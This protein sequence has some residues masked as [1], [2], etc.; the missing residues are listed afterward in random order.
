MQ[1]LNDNK[2]LTILI[3]AL[4]FYSA[5]AGLMETIQRS[6]ALGISSEPLRKENGIQ[7]FKTKLPKNGVVAYVTDNHY[8]LKSLGIL[9][10][11]LSPLILLHGKGQ[12]RIIKSINGPSNYEKFCKQY[13]S[14]KYIIGN[15]NTKS[16]YNDFCESNAVALI[17]EI[18]NITLFKRK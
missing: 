15:F 9:Q 16:K 10:Y 3:V 12:Q 6:Y 18:D 2:F 14:P 11:E 1:I 8:D 17:G 7:L 13:P 5:M 4:C